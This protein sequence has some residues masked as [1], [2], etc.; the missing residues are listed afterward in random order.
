MDVKT[1]PVNARIRGS[2]SLSRITPGKAKIGIYE[3]LGTRPRTTQTHDPDTDP[4]R[5]ENSP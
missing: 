3:G 5:P 1:G 2:N 4:S